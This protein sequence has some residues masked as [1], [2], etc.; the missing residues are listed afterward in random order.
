MFTRKNTLQW[1]KVDAIIMFDAL[2]NDF[3]TMLDKSN[4]NYIFFSFGKCHRDKNSFLIN[5]EAI[6][7]YV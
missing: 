4:K 7:H 1:Q 3:F 2:N 6:T 5:Y